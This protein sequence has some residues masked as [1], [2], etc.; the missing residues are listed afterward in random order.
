M[1]AVKDGLR[2]AVM[3]CA[4]ALAGASP[5]LAAITDYLGKPV[6][7]V[8]FV[9]EGRDTTDPSLSDLIETRVGMPLSMADVRESLVHLYSLGR[10]EDVRVDA[11]LIGAGVSVRCRSQPG[12]PGHPRRVRLEVRGPGRGRRS[13]A[14]RHCR[15]RRHAACRPRARAG[16][17][18]EG[19]AEG[20]RLPQCRGGARRPGR[21]YAS[22]DDAG[23]RYRS[24]LPH[25]PRHAGSEV[26]G[27]PG[28]PAVDLLKQLGLAQGPRTSAMRSTSASRSISRASGATATTRRRS[29][30][31]SASRTG[32]AWRT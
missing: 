17:G 1:D 3:G 26:T 5:A 25:G 18:R 6:A 16:A 29:H 11:T 20:A 31:P 10:F 7:G 9:I 2:A 15:A 21:A 13:A 23:F 8:R 27:S 30:R 4:L 19:C 32:I 24:G 28:I 22:H 12:P 14:T